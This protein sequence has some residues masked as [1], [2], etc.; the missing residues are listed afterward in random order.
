[1]AV[2]LYDT[3]TM[4]AAKEIFAP[5][6]SFLR[7]RY[8]PTSDADIFDTKK[9][10]IDY[11]DEQNNKLAPLVFPEAGGIPVDRRGYETHEFEPP[12]VAPERVLTA[13]H[14][15]DRQAGEVFGGSLS[16]IQRE[17]NILSEDLADLTRMIDLREEH[18]AAETLLNNAYTA[19]RYADKYGTQGEDVNIKFY[20]EGSNPAVYTGSGWTTSSTNILSDLANMADRLTSR[21]LAATDAVVAGDVADVIQHNSEIQELLDNR[22]YELGGIQPEELPNGAVLIGR[23]NAKGHILNIFAYTRTYT[24]EDGSTK[25]F[26]PA[27]SVVVTAPACGRM[28]YGSITQ[29][30][31]YSRD[32]V[33]YPGRR[34]PHVTTDSHANTRVLTLQAKPLAIPN[35]KNPFIFSKVLS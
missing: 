28:A 2:N 17:A 33:T 25:A 9:V 35:V 26:I 30:E 19:K 1:M 21:G 7:D 16:P 34:V 13:R 6:A 15:E 14:L 11:K 22:R 12:M 27:G 24:A 10:N 23:L 3:R 18:M 5:K 8:F 20:T 32:F 29:I 31:E 4:L